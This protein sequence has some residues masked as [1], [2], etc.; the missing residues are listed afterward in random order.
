MNDRMM[1]KLL[2]AFKEDHTNMMRNKVGDLQ[3]LPMI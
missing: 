3:S 1:Q 2:R